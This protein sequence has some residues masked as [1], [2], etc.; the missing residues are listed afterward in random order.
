MDLKEQIQKLEQS[1][2]AELTKTFTEI[3]NVK[4]KI[5]NKV[6]NLKAQMD[7]NNNKRSLEAIQQQLENAR[8][9]AI[10][11]FNRL[12]QKQ[13]NIRNTYDNE[14]QKQVS[15]YSFKPADLL[16]I[17]DTSRYEVIQ[18]LI[19][20]ST[21]DEISEMKKGLLYGG[22]QNSET[23]A[24]FNLALQKR[25]LNETDNG[26]KLTIKTI[27]LNNEIYAGDQADKD[28]LYYT[29]IQSDS[30]EEFLRK[31]GLENGLFKYNQ[32]PFFN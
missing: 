6:A 15:D 9:E 23:L 31:L 3:E 17:K 11:V 7:G 18:D 16:Q 28:R 1:R 22:P 27:L 14:I 4:P 21:I 10:N 24:L 2:D 5:Y 13:N 26:I 32:N 12:L 30:K 8:Q 29:L 20:I 19:N 25:Y